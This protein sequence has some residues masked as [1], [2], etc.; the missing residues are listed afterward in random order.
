MVHGKDWREGPLAHV[1]QKAI[2]ILAEWGGSVVE[3]DYTKGVSS[4]Q[5][6]KAVRDN[7][8]RNCNEK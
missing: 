4:T 5:F 3:P 8:C 1:R 6:K 2:D 7:D